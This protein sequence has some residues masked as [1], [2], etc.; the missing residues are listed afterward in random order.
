MPDALLVR[1]QGERVA[2]PLSGEQ[3]IAE[4]GPVAPLPNGEPLLLGLTTVQ[5]R[6]VPLVNLAPLLTGAPAADEPRLMVLTSL[7]GDRVALLVNE[8][9][10]VTALPTP[11]VSSALL[12]DLPGGPLLNP[13][14][15]ARELRDSLGQ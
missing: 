3:T 9:F 13:A 1:I 5:G 10:G 12:I 8:V 4:L 2:L 7:E 14:V 11:P 6:A 15:L